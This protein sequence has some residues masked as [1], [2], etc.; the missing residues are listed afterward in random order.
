MS[1]VPKHEI[2]RICDIP[3]SQVNVDQVLGEV[4]RVIQTQRAGAY[5]SIT[6]TESMYHAL[7]VLNHS[8]AF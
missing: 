8:T 5:I 2:A 1:A 4:N 3:I 7:R 6:N